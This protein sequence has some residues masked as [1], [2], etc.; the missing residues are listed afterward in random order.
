MREGGWRRAWDRHLGGPCHVSARVWDDG[1]VASQDTRTAWPPRPRLR[2]LH[3][4][5]DAGRVHRI[6]PRHHARQQRGGKTGGKGASVG[7]TYPSSPPASAVAMT[8]VVRS[9]SAVPSDWGASV[10]TV[11]ACARTGPILHSATAQLLPGST[12]ARTCLALFFNTLPS[13]ERKFLA[14]LNVTCGGRGG[15]FGLA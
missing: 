6:L 12:P 8:I 1:V 9:H 11:Q 10:G 3:G 4:P 13:M 15:T 7:A 5:A 2:T 14:S